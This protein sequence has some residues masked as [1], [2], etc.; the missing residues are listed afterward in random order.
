M[1]LTT[2]NKYQCRPRF[3]NIINIIKKEKTVSQRRL[4]NYGTNDILFHS[5]AYGVPRVN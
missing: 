5:E 3:R 4:C 1:I 2:D